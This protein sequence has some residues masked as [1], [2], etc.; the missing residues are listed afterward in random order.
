MLRVVKMK[1]IFL[2]WFIYLNYIRRRSFKY[3]SA[4]QSLTYFVTYQIFSHKS[5]IESI[6]LRRL[7]KLIYTLML[8][9]VLL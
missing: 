9:Y 4:V 2:N 1:F 3:F 6:F 5:I 7:S 8:S